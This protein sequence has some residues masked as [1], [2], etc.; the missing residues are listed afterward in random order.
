MSHHIGDGN[1]TFVLW[2]KSQGSCLQ[3][4]LPNHLFSP[5]I[6]ETHMTTKTSYSVFNFGRKWLYLSDNWKFNDYKVFN[7]FVH[8]LKNSVFSAELFLQFFWISV[9]ARKGFYILERFF[10][11]F[12]YLVCF[13]CSLSPCLS[14][15]FC[16]C[17]YIFVSVSF[18]INVSISL[19]WCILL[20]LTFIYCEF[21]K[22]LK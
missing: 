5:L 11:S 14:L 3:N 8:F 21:Y 12:L 6:M 20:L 2:K 1:Q 4:L 16:F 17:L 22:L 7:N 13:G 10:F 15:C 19:S 9:I 18:C